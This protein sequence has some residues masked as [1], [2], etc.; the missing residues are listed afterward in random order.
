LHAAMWIVVVTTPV[1][2]FVSPRHLQ[3]SCRRARRALSLSALGKAQNKQAELARKL[4]LAKQ[5]QRKEAGN[6]VQNISAEIDDSK[7]R[8]EQE[9]SEFA[10]LLAKNQ[11]PSDTSE[12]TFTRQDSFPSQSTKLSN[13]SSPKTPAVKRRKDK[14]ASNI[15]VDSAAEAQLPLREGDK[16]KRLHFERLV[17][18]STKQPLGPMAAAQLVPWVPPY[19]NPYLVVVVDPR[20]QSSEF[21]A[22]LQ[23]L[24]SA[25]NQDGSGSDNR[26][27]SNMIAITSDSPEETT[28]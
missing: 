25:R 19:L 21:R 6:D 28:A 13:P 14:V 11:P 26:P 20:K 5:Q 2:A 27:L 10:L 1:D 22:V 17:C 18:T 4:E 7:R 16:A 12:V 23:Y 3:P 8:L 9:R 15:P 24:T